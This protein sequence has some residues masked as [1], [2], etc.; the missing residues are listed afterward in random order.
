MKGKTGEGGR[1][2]DVVKEDDKRN[3]LGRREIIKVEVK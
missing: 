1:E 2:W 3:R